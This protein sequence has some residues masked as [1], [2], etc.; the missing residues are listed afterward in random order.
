MLS[1]VG[2]GTNTNNKKQTCGNNS[3][4]GEAIFSTIGIHDN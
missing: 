2:F 3:T 1:H 4:A